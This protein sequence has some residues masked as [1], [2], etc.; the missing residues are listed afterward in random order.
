V[1][2][3]QDALARIDAADENGRSR[4]LD[5]PIAEFLGRH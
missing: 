3:T 2:Y 1:R 5:A 4:P